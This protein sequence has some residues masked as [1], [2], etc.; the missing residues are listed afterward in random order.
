MRQAA[1]SIVI[2]T[3]MR[4]GVLVDTLRYVRAL[5]GERDEVVVVDQT[6]EHEPGTTAALETLARDGRV[7]WVRKERPGISEAM[8][9][10]ALLARGD[11][12]L[13][14]DD[15]VVPG[16]GLLEEHRAALS[17][18]GGALSTCGQILQPWDD[19]PAGSVRDREMGFDFS[20]SGPAEIVPV[21]AG[22]FGVRRETFL[23]VGGMDEVFE[24][25]AHRC[26]AEV[27]YRLLARTG[28]RTRFVPGASLRHLLAGGGTR[29]HGHKDSWAAI[30]SA[31]GD[32]YF[33][34]RCLG[35][36]GAVRHAARRVAR[37]PF[38]R[39]TAR[40]PWLV[41]SILLREAVAF[42]RAALLAARPGRYV[43]PLEAYDD[44][45]PLDVRAR[46]AA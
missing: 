27:G 14:L 43:R 2:P 38:N 18:E 37:A 4:E 32:Y 22:N 19:A 7:R 44:V 3:Y 33:G 6:P 11:L 30:G 17:E 36:G 46:G 25:G 16:T 31:V 13:F 9:V 29:A 34:F 45:R 1:V 26:D 20:Y 8:N 28:R 12:V 10:G 15:D 40:R 5:L 35:L 39:N 23:A 21:M 42:L 41:L 24:G